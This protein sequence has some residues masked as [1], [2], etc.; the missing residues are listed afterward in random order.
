[1]KT[2]PKCGTV[3]K[4]DIAFCLE[5]G[6]PLIDTDG[7]PET[8]LRTSHPFTPPGTVACSVCGL[9]NHA[10]A[11]FCEQ[12]G[13]VFPFQDETPGGGYGQT[14]PVPSPDQDTA[15]PRNQNVLIGILAGLS[16]VLLMVIVY[17]AGGGGIIKTDGD[18][19][20][21]V[22]NQNINSPSPGNSPSPSP[23]K[24]TPKPERSPSPD[25]G[26]EEDPPEDPPSLPYKFEKVFRGRSNVDLTMKLNKNGST[27]TGTAVTPAD[28]DYLSG[29]IDSDGNFDLAG[30][31]QREGY[32]TGHWRGQIRPDGSI[33]GVWTANNGRQISYSASAK[34]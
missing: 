1:M 24:G 28:I 6:T 23:T 22:N 31:N 18:L 34:R 15:R 29:S 7:E 10:N 14:I 27:L 17:M 21:K 19:R 26:S 4:G 20:A 5:D 16:V 32:V 30:D 13:A 33:R 11:K 25:D 2:C 3:Y 12:C 9:G 8:V